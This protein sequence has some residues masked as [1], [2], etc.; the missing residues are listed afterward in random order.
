MAHKNVGAIPNPTA[1][2]AADEAL[3]TLSRNAFGVVGDNLRRSRFKQAAAEAMRVVSAANKYISD[4]EP[5][6]KKDDVAR[7][8]TI[9][10][11]A[12]Q[13]VQD[14]NTLLTPFLPHAAQKI[15]E[16]LGNAGVWAAQPELQDVED[17]D[18]PGQ[19]NPILTGDYAA[20]QAKW[21]SMP[22]EVGRPLEKPSPLFTKLD[23]K[24]GETGPS[25][26]PVVD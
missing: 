13:V 1:P 11:T 5:W 17:L 24:L 9:L 7:R 14:A 8:D 16:A 25:W 19:I 23:P 10:H 21:E 18:V 2:T 22:L 26:A 12:L 20:E 15:H 6:K 3:K 4:Q